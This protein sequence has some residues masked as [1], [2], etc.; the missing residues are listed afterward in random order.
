MR[1]AKVVLSE[2]IIKKVDFLGRTTPI[3]SIQ[4]N[5]INI[6]R[7]RYNPQFVRFGLPYA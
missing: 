7:W 2:N 1:L 5:I 4:I 6:D 3:C